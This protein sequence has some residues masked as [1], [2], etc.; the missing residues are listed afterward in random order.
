MSKPGLL[1]A[2]RPT[3]L[4]TLSFGGFAFWWFVI[5]VV[6]LI[7]CLFNVCYAKFYWVFGDTF[8]SYSLE[9]YKIGM[10]RDNFRSIPFT[11]AALAVVHGVPVLFM[12]LGF[13]RQRS[14]VFYP[15]SDPLNKH[16]KA[17]R[18]AVKNHVA[19][20]KTQTRYRESSSVRRSTML[21]LRRATKAIVNKHSVVGV[22]GRYFYVVFVFREAI[23][24]A[25]Q[26]V[27]AI[28][29]SQYLSRAYLNRFY[30]C[31]LVINCWSSVLVHSRAFGQDSARRRFVAIVCD[32]ALDLMSAVGVSSMIVL[33]YAGQYDIELGSFGF[34]LLQD[35]AWIARMLSE[36]RLVVVT[37]WSDLIGRAVFSLGVLA[38]T[39]NM[40]ELLAWTPRRGQRIVSMHNIGPDTEP[41]RLVGS[42]RL[43]VIDKRS[44]PGK[45]QKNSVLNS[46]ED[47]DLVPQHT[48]VVSG[49]PCTERVLLRAMHI[50]LFALGVSMIILH[51]QASLKTPLV[52]CTPKVK[53]MAG[54][55]PACFAVE[56][57]CHKLGI[58]GT[59]AD[60][61]AE[62]SKFDHS[63][64]VK[65]HIMHCSALEMPELLQEFRQLREFWIYNSTITT[66]S[67]S[68]A[69]TNSHYPDLAVFS[70][71]RSNV[72]DGLLPLGLQSSDFPLQLTQIYFCKTNLQTLPDDLDLKWNAGS[73]IYV[74]ASEL[75][76][77]PQSLARLRPLYLSLAGNPIIELPAEL[78]ESSSIQYLVLSSTNVREL[79][80]GVML[81]AP[82]VPAFFDFA[83][84]QIA[85]FWA[86]ID[87]FVESMLGTS[88]RIA[89]GGTP[90]CSDLEG[91]F[92]GAATDFSAPFKPQQSRL[93]MNSST[94]NWEI[95]LQAVDCSQRAS[96]T[97]FPLEYWDALYGMSV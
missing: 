61:E 79:P 44:H 78:F 21:M 80:R 68:A 12:V 5:L 97:Q 10:G 48:K 28:R 15:W 16:V 14:L 27:Q 18:K 72:T 19:E 34:E 33:S 77:V 69:I 4:V 3:G 67:A 46:R 62:W 73:N 92:S 25:F 55:H 56:F 9:A 17:V 47:A 22:K 7:A 23:E 57:D 2:S 65:L 29:M 13:I 24:T 84:T 40:K 6:H 85:F 36:A 89:A 20:M 64:V 74:E 90:Y 70:L 53:P 94:E 87:P 39:Y 91:I 37:S 59:K 51:V 60:V 45:L 66:W 63:T 52:E 41:L 75:T 49:L 11:H 96:L 71:V 35:D 50:A 43:Q 93:L 42:L 88:P 38:A 32:C 81:E 54:A 26:T 86:W 8:L 95:L 83:D 30:T 76:A 1:S 31:L 82:L 58:S